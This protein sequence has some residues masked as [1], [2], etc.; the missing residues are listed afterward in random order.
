LQRALHRIED[1]GARMGLLV[2]DLLL[3]A[4]LDQGR[5]LEREPV[6]V[7]AI[8]GDA[9]GDARAVDPE[10][11]IDLSIEE[12]LTVMGDDRRLH[13]VVA[14]LL[15]NAR[16]H[17][18]PGTPVS[19]RLSR[20]GDTATLEVA[21]RGPGM[22]PE[23]SA[24]VFER[25]YRGDPSRSRTSGGTGLGLSIASAIVRAHGG[26]ITAS[27]SPG[28]GASFLVS[29]PLAPEALAER[30]DGSAETRPVEQTP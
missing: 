17:T 4:R 8:A 20:A 6:D 22:T 15:E 5:P 7:A 23:E 27:S 13:Q 19:V 21:D 11:P 10:R 26:E 3:L 28:E 30:L 14:N 29:L 2:D 16:I 1:E 18:P 24:S 9:V 12:P 25:F